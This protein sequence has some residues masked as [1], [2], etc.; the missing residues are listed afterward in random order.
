MSNFEPKLKGYCDEFVR[1]IRR[2]AE[3]DGQVEFK[4]WFH[5]LA[6]DVFHMRCFL[7]EGLRRDFYFA[8]FLRVE[9]RR[10]TLLHQGVE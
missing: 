8:G 3:S 9:G 1:A 5:R 7:K 6:F 4:D 2:V 10:D